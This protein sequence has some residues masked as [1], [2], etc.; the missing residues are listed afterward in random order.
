MASRSLPSQNGHGFSQ[1]QAE[2]HQHRTAI[3]QETPT[4]IRE[5]S[6][7]SPSAGGQRAR[8]RPSALIDQLGFATAAR[9]SPR[10]SHSP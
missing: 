4:R 10:L 5:A 9:V 2:S 6:S 7:M 8:A 1:A 3:L